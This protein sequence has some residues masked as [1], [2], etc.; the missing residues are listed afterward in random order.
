MGKGKRGAAA[1]GPGNC[2]TETLGDLPRSQSPR[3][4]AP[5]HTRKLV[6][7]AKVTS[8]QGQPPDCSWLLPSSL[9]EGGLSRATGDR[10]PGR[11]PSPTH[12]RTCLPCRSPSGW[13]K[14]PNLVGPTLDGKAQMDKGPESTP[15]VGALGPG[16]CPSCLLTTREAGKSRHPWA[17]ERLP[18]MALGWQPCRPLCRPPASP[19]W[20]SAGRRL[21]CHRDPFCGSSV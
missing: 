14:P 2:G 20:A 21:P 17:L 19:C 9:F 7:R 8:G 1:C 6:P 16:A 5:T 3:A 13:P 10:R 11:T 15:H 18:V 12:S 4:P